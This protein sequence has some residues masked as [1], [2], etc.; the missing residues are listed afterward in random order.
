MQKWIER[1]TSQHGV[2]CFKIINSLFSYISEVNIT[3]DP[4]IAV[5]APSAAGVGILIVLA[6]SL[7]LLVIVALD[8]W[9]LIRYL[10]NIS[11]LQAVF[12][13]SID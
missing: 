13:K 11:R 5:E 12:F 9:T 7:L 8:L 4:D 2:R 3:Q 1:M 6:C 10:R